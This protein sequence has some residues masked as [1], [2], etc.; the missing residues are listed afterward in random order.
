MSY[1]RSPHKLGY[2]SGLALTT[3]IYAPG[4]EKSENSPISSNSLEV[5][6]VTAQVTPGLSTPQDILKRGYDFIRNNE[7]DKLNGIFFTGRAEELPEAV[8]REYDAVKVESELLQINRNFQKVIGYIKTPRGRKEILEDL[9][10]CLEKGELKKEKDGSVRAY[11]SK[12]FTKFVVG[13]DR[14]GHWKIVPKL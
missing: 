5:V 4:C 6:I 2:L 13:K 9:K 7:Y 11:S 10:D 8:T 12:G 1:E 3:L 14:N